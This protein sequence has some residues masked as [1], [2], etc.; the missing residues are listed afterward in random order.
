MCCL[1]VPPGSLGPVRM[2]S[3]VEEEY[4][5]GRHHRVMKTV[6]YLTRAAWQDRVGG[7]TGLHFP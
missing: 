6:P 2:F 7:L 1:F 3:V 5:L 4:Q